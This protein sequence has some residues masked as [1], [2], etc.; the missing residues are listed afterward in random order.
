M[1]TLSRN[2]A[3]IALAFGA[4]GLAM[5]PAIASA[6]ENGTYQA[7]TPD[8][9]SGA[10]GARK[11]HD[12]WLAT[13]PESASGQNAS[14]QVNHEVLPNN[15][16]G[17]NGA[18]KAYDVRQV[19]EA[20]HAQPNPN[21]SAIKAAFSQE[22]ET[23]LQQVHEARVALSAGDRVSAK[24]LMHNARATLSDMYNEGAHGNIVITGPLVFDE[25]FS[26]GNQLQ[27]NAQIN[28]VIL[29]FDKTRE[30]L[31]LAYTQLINNQPFQANQTLGL[32]EQD[33]G[34]QTAQISTISTVAPANS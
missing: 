19:K 33:L 27:G 2:I 11:A 28:Q 12:I 32:V 3:I 22:G 4:S 29:P 9:T 5:M 1:K 17:P 24:K 14:P 26:A 15:H 13:H 7:I 18:R 16:A 34:I 31:N 6:A 8:N 30:N 10:H 23:V 25:D 21:S 20:E